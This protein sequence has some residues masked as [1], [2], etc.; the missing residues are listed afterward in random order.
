MNKAE[1][2]IYAYSISTRLTITFLTFEKT[3]YCNEAKNKPRNEIT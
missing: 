3:F 2:K 1:N